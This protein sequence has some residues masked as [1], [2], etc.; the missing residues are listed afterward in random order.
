LYQNYPNP[1]NSS[2]TVR[3][4]LPQD[5]YVTIEIINV[6]GQVVY[7]QRRY[8]Q[9]GWHQFD[10]DGTDNSGASVASGVYYYRV[11]TY[12]SSDSKKM[13]LLK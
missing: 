13:L 10:W 12:K 4:D 7:Q 9:A 2:T 8:Y 11:S 3:F 5:G 6:L 1:F